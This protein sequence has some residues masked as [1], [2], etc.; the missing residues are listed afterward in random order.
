MRKIYTGLRN[1]TVGAI[2]YSLQAEQ[3]KFMVILRKKGLNQ[4]AL[5]L[6]A[7]GHEKIYK[8]PYRL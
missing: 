5:N 3:N 6:I 2:L 1:L 8:R 7:V 4:E